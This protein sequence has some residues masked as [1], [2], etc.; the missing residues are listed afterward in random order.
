MKKHTQL[1]W[2]KKILQETGQ[3]S[4]N[5]CLQNYLSRL[6]ARIVDLKKEG[7]IFETERKNGDYIYK[8]LSPKFRKITYKLETGEIING[9]F[10]KVI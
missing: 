3:I 9:G 2:I 7:W 5:L 8:L 10:E 4:R 6:G 1:N